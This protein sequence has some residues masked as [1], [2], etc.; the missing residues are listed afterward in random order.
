MI[1]FPS[2]F[3]IQQQYYFAGITV[4]S[5]KTDLTNKDQGNMFVKYQYYRNWLI[6]AEKKLK[7]EHRSICQRMDETRKNI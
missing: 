7:S 5:E 6:E 2:E 3:D 1:C 4:S